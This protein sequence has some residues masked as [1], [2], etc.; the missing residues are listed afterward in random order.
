MDTTIAMIVP[1]SIT[2]ERGDNKENC[3]TFLFYTRKCVNDHALK[4]STIHRYATDSSNC[5]LTRLCIK[6]IL[7]VGGVFDYQGALFEADKSL[8]DIALELHGNKHFS[9]RDVEEFCGLSCFKHGAAFDKMGYYSLFVNVF[10][11]LHYKGISTTVDDSI[12]LCMF[13]GL[14]CNGTSA[15]AAVWQTLHDMI[16]KVINWLND[17]DY[18][19]KLFKLLLK[20]Y[21]VKVQSDDKNTTVL[22]GNSKSPRF[23][24][25]NYSSIVAE[26]ASDIHKTIKEFVTWKNG[27]GKGKS[28]SSQHSYLYNKLKKVKGIGPLS[29]NQLWHSMCLCGIL[30]PTH[31]QCTAVAPG[32]GPAKLIKTFYP[33]ISKPELFSKKISDVRAEL[34]KVG[35]KKISEFF[36]ENLFCEVWRIA[37]VN[38]LL[39]KKQGAKEDNCAMFLSDDFQDYIRNAKPTRNPDIYYMNPFTNDYQHLFRVDTELIMRP[40]FAGNSNASSINLK[41]IIHHDINSGDTVV[42]LQGD[43]LTT[44]GMEPSQLFV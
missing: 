9:C 19:T 1:S 43:Y 2:N 20:L 22:Y 34:S 3:L 24:Y 7:Q 32:S 6:C 28:K 10:L 21:R 11:S 26:N 31:I 5:D 38:K 30:P 33:Y 41:T 23:Q 40:S 13:F 15:L 35:L 8:N 14:I 44:I 42:T 25:A 36:I 4:M 39:V 16:Q 18:P 37:N 17:R 29:F 27:E 12:S